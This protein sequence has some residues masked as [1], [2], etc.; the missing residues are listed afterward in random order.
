MK[1]TTFPLCESIRNCGKLPR[2]SCWKAK[3]F[4]SFVEQ[5]IRENIQRRQLQSEFVQ[6]GLL[7]SETARQNNAYL[8]ADTVVG[9]T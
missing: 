5:S 3:A 4:P 2:K 6:R 8:S 1:T 7:S 9:R